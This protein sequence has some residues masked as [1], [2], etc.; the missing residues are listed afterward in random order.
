MLLRRVPSFALFAALALP[1]VGLAGLT[2]CG[3]TVN[4]RTTT[5]NAAAVAHCRVVKRW[6]SRTRPGVANHALAEL[7]Y[8]N[9]ERVGAPRY[10]AEAIALAQEIQRHLGHPVTGVFSEANKTA[11]AKYQRR[12]PGL[13]NRRPPRWDGIVGPRTYRSITGHN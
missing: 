9:L 7:A 4:V 8:R 12:H 13:W 6:V 11:V 1:A 5:A 2:A 10:G 3:S